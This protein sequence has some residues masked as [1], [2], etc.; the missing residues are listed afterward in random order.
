MVF[1]TT[2]QLLCSAMSNNTLNT[3]YNHSANSTNPSAVHIRPLWYEFPICAVA[4]YGYI[5][6]YGVKVFNL[7]VGTPCNILVIWQIITKKSDA[8]TSD[9]FILNLAILDAYFCL[10][11]PV[12]LVN[13]LLLNDN[14]IW[15]FKRL[16]YGIKDLAPLFLV[17]FSFV[18]LVYQM[19]S[20]SLM[21]EEIRPLE[22]FLFCLV[23]LPVQ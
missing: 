2:F 14:G 8:F 15:Y 16:A 18:A 9:T 1:L 22:C 21:C 6:Y 20:D 13:G 12:D 5:F 11:T 19:F 17:S 23:A 4:P 10:M 3:A 7:A